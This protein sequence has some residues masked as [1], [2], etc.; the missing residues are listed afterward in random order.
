MAIGTYF[1]HLFASAFSPFTTLGPLALF[2]SISLLMEG[3]ADKKRHKNDYIT[4]TYQCII[5]E[6]SATQKN[7]K[8]KAA[9]AAAA[10]EGSNDNTS[11]YHED[12]TIPANVS[13][14]SPQTT[15]QFNY[16]QR[17]DIRQ[18]QLVVIRNR[19]MIPADTVLLASSGDRGCAYIETSSI[20]GETNLKL[21]LSAMSKHDKK[22]AS[23]HSHESIEDAVRRISKFTAIGFPNSV[24]DD[25]SEDD[26]DIIGV[27]TTEP[28][29]AHVNTFSG[30]LTMP[31]SGQTDQENQQPPRSSSQQSDDENNNNDGEIIPL[32]GDNLLLRGMFLLFVVRC[33]LFVVRCSLFVV[34]CSLFVAV[35]VALLVVAR[36]VYIFVFALILHPLFFLS[37]F[38]YFY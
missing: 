38:I 29:D 33:S 31:I 36:V 3:I 15:V 10:A 2:I 11:P 16:S 4:N 32:G 7:S 21:R 35:A 24:I 37:F 23:T 30:K 25:D 8:T 9:A 26:D 13:T 1:P 5:M 20:D 27:L 34:R 22:I 14:A 17:K 6:N 18:G 12:V 28:P 19:E